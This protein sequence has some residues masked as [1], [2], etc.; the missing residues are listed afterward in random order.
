MA[1]SCAWARIEAV[2]EIRLTG[3]GE[4]QPRQ[5]VAEK[6]ASLTDEI[7]KQ[8][9]ASRRKRRTIDAHPVSTLP[10]AVYPGRA[11]L[12][13]SRIRLEPVDPRIHA[14]DLF[15]IGHADEDALA[16]W[17]YL[18][19]GPFADA[20][21]MEGWL[22]SCAASCDPVFVAVRDRGSGRLAGMASFLEIRPLIGVIEIGH[23]WFA[24]PYQRGVHATEALY[25]MMRHAM[26][27]L[28]NRRLEWKCNALNQ[29]SRRAALRLGFR[30]EGV[31]FNH[32]IVKGCNRDT[33]WYSI[34]DTEWPA[35]QS[36]FDRWLAASN[37]DAE[38]KQRSSL[39]ERN[40][41]LW[42]RVT[43]ERD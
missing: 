20:P 41:S 16:L 28:E 24:P 1:V 32:N 34:I 31:F 23:I 25:L 18:P 40:R 30:F 6:E 37:F 14:R 5:G 11:P 2:P 9:E 39:G 7:S 21:G 17:K 43:G 15:A 36:N 42:Q 13:A 29:A 27:D 12:E 3:T 35:I 33:A 26:L 8:D 19:Y 10:P 22:R 38:G 4:A